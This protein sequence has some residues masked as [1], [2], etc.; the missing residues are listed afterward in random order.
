MKILQVNKF[1]YLRGGA[2]R[3][4][5][6]ISRRLVET[7][8][9][10]AVFSM[11]HPKNW[12]GHWNKYFVSRISFNEAKLRD[13][14]LAPGRIIYSLEA[15]RKFT[16]LVQDFRPDIIHIHNIYHQISPSIL[17]VAKEYKIPVVMHVHDYKLVC[18][19]YK[20]YT[21]GQ[22]CYRCLGKKYCQATMHKC[23][24][25]S[26]LASLLVSVEMYIH[27][28]LL[29]IYENNV[30]H[31]IA[32]SEFMAGTLNNFSYPINNLSILYNFIDAKFFNTKIN[33]SPEEYLL[34]Y[35]RLSD[36]KGIFTLIG[37]MD[38]IENKKLKLLIV[39][40]G[41]AL[42]KLKK[43]SWALNLGKRVEFVGAKYGDEL[44][45]LISRAK[46]VV[47][48]SVWLENMPFVLLESL[49]LGKVVIASNIGG[50][51]EIITDNKNGFLFKP[52]DERDLAKKI[53]NLDKVDLKN[54][55]ESARHSVSA[56]TL[57]N[58]LAELLLVYN[59]LI[60]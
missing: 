46:A 1:N 14:F 33:F 36:E 44:N 17:D 13:R 58:H 9:E 38:R 4:F 21:E 50:M 34:Y 51:P 47:I 7:G 3:Y 2:E 56:L 12:T 6:E 16:K 8:H 45:D 39:G 37:A 15:K 41:P 5:L 29:K 27:H 20:L 31:Y 25:G 54:I 24:R 42:G 55:A 59:N 26:F 19:N 18:P 32:P 57:D 48:P 53:D 40:D 52:G 28:K 43:E 23:F 35:G 60:K 22:V 30:S 49:A 11:H 10:V